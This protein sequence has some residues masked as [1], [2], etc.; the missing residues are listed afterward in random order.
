MEQEFSRLQ[1]RLQQAVDGMLG[2]VSAQHVRPIQREGYLCSAKCCE[3]STASDS[4][5][6]QCLQHCSQ[7]SQQLQAALQNEMQSFQSRLSRCAQTCQ[8]E[9]NDGIT[10]EMRNDPSKMGPLEQKMLKCSNSCV[11]KHIAMLP[12]VEAK[13][14]AAIKN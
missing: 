1:T 13:I 4:Q 3:S 14:I 5:V 2:K 6:E 10:P 9:V 11:D 12:S 8:D 7:R